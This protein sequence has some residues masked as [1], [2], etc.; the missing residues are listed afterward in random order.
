MYYSYIEIEYVATSFSPARTDLAL[1]LLIYK[2]QQC[3]LVWSQGRA[4]PLMT[5][6]MLHLLFVPLVAWN[7]G[8]FLPHQCAR[9]T[10]ITTAVSKGMTGICKL[11]LVGHCNELS[12][13]ILLC[14]HWP[15]LLSLSLC[16]HKIIPSFR[17][18]LPSHQWTDRSLLMTEFLWVCHCS[19]PQDTW[20]HLSG[21]L[22][23]ASVA[24]FHV[25]KPNTQLD[26]PTY[27]IHV[28]R[29]AH[30]TY[31]D[32]AHTDILCFEASHLD[33]RSWNVQLLR[34]IFSF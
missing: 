19:W 26:V 24:R 21:R 4:P 13:T 1:K 27:S 6:T 28:N 12:T 11:Q 15:H 3:T 32:Q 7:I 25:P 17:M 29:G 2:I 10:K 9:T 8:E 31:H 16:G 14:H 33:K 5:P 20:L 30:V 34:P 18:Y 23:R 22:E